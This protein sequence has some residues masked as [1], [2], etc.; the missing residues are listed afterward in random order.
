MPVL[1][2]SQF[3]MPSQVAANFASSDYIRVPVKAAAN[4]TS[5]NSRFAMSSTPKSPTNSKIKATG[6]NSPN[7]LTSLKFQAKRNSMPAS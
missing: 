3:Q 2:F 6:S 4:N 7:N 5:Y 1:H